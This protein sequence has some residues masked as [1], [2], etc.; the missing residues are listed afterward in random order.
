MTITKSKESKEKTARVN[1]DLKK[2]ECAIE[3]VALTESVTESV[4]LTELVKS[5]KK[6]LY[7]DYVIY[8]RSDRSKYIVKHENV[9]QARSTISKILL[10]FSNKKINTVF[11]SVLKSNNQIVSSEKDANCS[12]TI[13]ISEYLDSLKK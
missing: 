13:S 9:Q 11:I 8:Y 10:Y 2:I 1:V 7:C 12:M 4:A 5:N 3:S 6:Q